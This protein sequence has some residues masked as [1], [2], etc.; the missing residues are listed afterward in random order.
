MK[1]CLA[2]AAAGL[3]GIDFLYDSPDGLVR[4]DWMMVLAA[5]GIAVA[6]SMLAGL[7]PAWRVCRIPPA[8][9]LKTQ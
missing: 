6:G 8:T 2:L 1:S 9:Q 7:Y 5:I 3:Q 4:L